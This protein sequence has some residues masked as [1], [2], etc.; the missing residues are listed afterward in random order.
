MREDFLHYLWRY[1]KFDASDL[2]TTNHEPVIILNAGL[3]TQLS[4][5]DFFNAQLII[6]DQ[7]WAGNI[8]IHLKSS[9]W[10]SHRHESDKAYENV[11]LHVVWEHDAD[12][13]RIDNTEIPVL[14]LKNFTDPKLV[15]SVETLTSVKSWI[16]CEK[17]LDGF[18]PFV[19]KN[20][21]E[22]L[23]FDRLQS[24]SEMINQLLAHSQNDWEAV[25]F[26]MLAKNFGL[27]TN[28]DAF[29]RL[30]MQIP[31]AIIRRE[32]EINLNLESLLFGFAGLLDD[33]KQDTYFAALKKCNSMLIQKYQLE[34]PAPIKIEF[35]KHR[36]DN[37]PTIR[38]SQFA[39]LYVKERQL[40]AKVLSTENLA[41]I[42]SLFNVS[43][44]DYWVTHFQFDRESPPKVKSLSK[45]FIDLLIINTL[46][47]IRFAYA[48]SRGEDVTQELIALISQIKPESNAIIEKYN[49]IKLHASSAMETQALLQMK[50]NYCS[51]GKCLECAI[52]IAL[53]KQPQSQ[54]V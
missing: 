35:F 11:I 10:Y 48:A 52:G 6:N 24:K 50:S 8:E 16:Y 2:Y 47:P 39:S 19:L 45:P 18:D 9:D 31:Y 37:F 12:I 51:R 20:W 21:L 30:A 40:F 46:V 15:E 4:G 22:R 43:V 42:Y 32:S 44:S 41:D 14:E 17:Q 3:Y 34:A 29:L 49:S 7:K 23:F 25:L 38:L 36:P 26:C 1:K 5:P 54:I 13:Y 53:L 28:G 33:E 27:N